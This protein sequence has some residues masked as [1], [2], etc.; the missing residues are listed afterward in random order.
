MGHETHAAAG[1]I[2]H[3]AATRATSTESVRHRI[4]VRSDSC[5]GG[6][7]KMKN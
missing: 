3:S 4:E 1:G 7:M 6:T 5:G 2:A